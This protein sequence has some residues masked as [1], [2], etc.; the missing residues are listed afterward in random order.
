MKVNPFATVCRSHKM[1]VFPS[2]DLTAGSTVAFISLPYH[3]SSLRLSDRFP[4]G[5]I[6][7]TPRI[8][9]RLDNISNVLLAIVVPKLRWELEKGSSRW[10]IR[11]QFAIDVCNLYFS[12]KDNVVIECVHKDLR[13][14]IIT[15]YKFF[16]H[17]LH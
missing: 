13:L 6:E 7:Y 11:F 15:T 16:H 3:L 12:I 2:D 8:V 5:T 4:V 1:S 17:R 9:S 10:T 14:V